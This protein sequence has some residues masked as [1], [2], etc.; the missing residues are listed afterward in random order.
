MICLLFS[1]QPIAFGVSLLHSYIWISYL[2]FSGLFCHV[3]LN[4]DQSDWDW[5]LRL[6]DVINRVPFNRVRITSWVQC[7]TWVFETQER[8]EERKKERKKER[9]LEWRSKYKRLYHDLYTSGTSLQ[10]TLLRCLH[11]GIL[12]YIYNFHDSVGVYHKLYNR[13][14]VAHFKESNQHTSTVTRVLTWT[15][16]KFD[17][18]QQTLGYYVGYVCACVCVCVCVRK[19]VLP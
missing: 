12:I 5:R 16:I 14:Y 8:K 19:C 7:L 2:I 4:R 15:Q 18:S 1:V 13:A 17:F 3:P 9:K 10:T 11:N 6:N